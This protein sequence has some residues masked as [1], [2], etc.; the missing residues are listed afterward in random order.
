MGTPKAKPDTVT[1]TPLFDWFGADKKNRKA[2]RQ[3]GYTDGRITN[4]KKRGIP[5][6]EVE[7][8]AKIMGLTYDQYL[9]AAGAPVQAS[10]GLKLALEE[11]EAMRRLQKALPAWRRYV[12]GLAMVDSEQAQELLLTTM[13]QAVP[14]YDVRRAYG[15]AP[16]VAARQPL[17]VIE[18]GGA[19][20]KSRKKRQKR[21]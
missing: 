2:L 5:R 16:H 18:E 21:E 9:G 15:D 19:A 11:A 4:W 12:L 1:A 14:D 20:D 13:R 3:A 7:G 17:A 8:V 6:G 10:H